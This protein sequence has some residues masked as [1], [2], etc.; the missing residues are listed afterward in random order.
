LVDRVRSNHGTLTNMDAANDW[1]VSGGRGALD[2]DA[3]ND[4]VEMGVLTAIDAGDVSFSFWYYPFSIT[5]LA[6][7]FNNWSTAVVDRGFFC[8]RNG[9]QIAFQQPISSNRVTTS[10]GSLTAA[11]WHHIVCTK[12]SVSG[13]L[14]VYINGVL[15]GNSATSG[16][17][18]SSTA[19]FN[20]GGNYG[21]TGGPNCLLDD[22]IVFNASTTANEVREIYRLGRGYGVFP[23]PDFDEGFAA[24]GFKAYWARRQHLIGSGVY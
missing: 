24:A 15:D 7:I 10:A 19:K 20:I 12:T 8:F 9:S 16:G 4:Y 17:N 3:T 5:G 2:F 1:V 14:R 18:Q 22:F 23:E 6:T 11:T 21:G 13:G